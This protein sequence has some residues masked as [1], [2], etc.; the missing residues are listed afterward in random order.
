MRIVLCSRSTSEFS[1]PAR[2]VVSSPNR[3]NRDKDY[4]DRD[5]RDD[6]DRDRRPKGGKSRQY[7][8]DSE[9]EE[10]E[11]RDRDRRGARDRDRDRDRGSRNKPRYEEEEVD[12]DDRDRDRGGRDRERDRDGPRRSKPDY[13]DGDRDDRRARDRRDEGRDRDTRDRG[14]GG[15]EG[16][17]GGKQPSQERREDRREERRRTDDRDRDPR[18]EETAAAPPAVSNS[19][20]QDQPPVIIPTV[21][22]NLTNMRAFLSSPAPKGAG[23]LQC[24]IRRNKSGTNKF[25]PVY[26]LYL[27]DGDRL[28]LQ[29][30]KRANNK[31]SNYLITMAEN[32]FNRDSMNYLGKL[33]SNFVGTEFNVYDNGAAPKGIK[34]EELEETGGSNMSPRKELAGIMYAANVMG[35][36]G[37]RKMQVAVPVVDEDQD[38]GARAVGSNSQVDELVNRIKDRNM[39][40]IV[41]MINKPPRWNEQVAAYVLNFNGRVTM[42]S[43]KNFQ[44]VDPD[45]QSAVLLQVCAHVDICGWEPFYLDFIPY[46]TM[47]CCGFIVC[48]LVVLARMSLRWTSS[49]PSRHSRHLV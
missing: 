27:K 49:G 22:I 21:A 1:R 6:R 42:A 18:R 12:Y 23:V 45:E 5:R 37:P 13:D 26:T 43:V 14:G 17:R 3:D 20:N 19:N 39:R 8:E 24:Y 47:Y 35:S 16:T 31:T 4:D 34:G 41:Y 44:L 30:K 48:S 2:P 29:S 40:D 7:Y 11:D 38:R 25:N 32:D 15:W 33:R 28:L 36:R 46:C 10:Q 9:E